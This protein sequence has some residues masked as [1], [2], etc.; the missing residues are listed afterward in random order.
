MND[1][2]VYIN[3]DNEFNKSLDD[4]IYKELT[5]KRNQNQ[6][7][8]SLSNIKDMNKTSFIDI[9]F[10]QKDSNYSNNIIKYMD[11]NIY[12]EEKQIKKA[13]QFYI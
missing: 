9:T 8:V 1:N 7:N 2:S 13:K 4:F 11:N 10:R 3:F 12:I 6:T 5:E